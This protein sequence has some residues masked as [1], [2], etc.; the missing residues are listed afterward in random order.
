MNAWPTWKQVTGK[1][2]EETTNLDPRGS[3]LI[4]EEHREQ[5]AE[6]ARENLAL[7]MDRKLNTHGATVTYSGKLIGATDDLGDTL[8]EEIREHANRW[9]Y[10]PVLNDYRALSDYNKMIHEFRKSARL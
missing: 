9:D 2:W 3:L 6:E 10:Y 4:T 5:M 1:T 8:R 7:H